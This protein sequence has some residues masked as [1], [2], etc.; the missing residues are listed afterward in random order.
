MPFPPL[1]LHDAPWPPIIYEAFQ[2]LKDRYDRAA[3]TLARSALDVP[4]ILFHKQVIE[5]EVVAL[6]NALEGQIQGEDVP[7]NLRAWFRQAINSF[8]NL[9]V[10]VYEAEASGTGQDSVRTIQANPVAIR[11]IGR[12][13]RPRKTI[14]QRLLHEAMAPHRAVSKSALA[15][16]LKIARGTLLKC[17]AEEDI[18]TG[19]SGIEDNELDILTREFRKRY[20]DSGIRYLRGF[21]RKYGLRIPRRRVVSSLKRTSGVRHALRGCH[22]KIMRRKYQVARPNAL[23]H[24]DGH[25]KL[26]RWGIVIHGIVDGYSRAV[27]GI[28]ASTSNKASTVLDVFMEAIHSY[29]IPS[30]VRGDRG[31]ENRDVSLFMILAR[32]PS[33]ASFMW[34]PSTR[35]TRIERLWGEVGSQFARAWRGFFLRLERL[36]Y[37]KHSNPHHLWLIQFIFLDAIN[38]DCKQFQENWNDHPISGVGHDKSPNDLRFLGQLEH[39]VYDGDLT[40]TIQ[41]V[42]HQVCLQNGHDSD[43]N[44]DIEMSDPLDE[45]DTDSGWTDMEDN[46]PVTDEWVR[47]CDE[48]HGKQHDGVKVPRISC[49]FTSLGEQQVFTQQLQQLRQDGI[50]PFGYGIHAEEWGNAGYPSFEIIKSGRGKK[51]LWVALPDEVWRARAEL[52]V[53]SLHLLTMFQ[54]IMN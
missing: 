46:S 18:T 6:F 19:F 15:R 24:I 26:I 10:Q 48:V 25:H 38:E 7:D 53:Q 21:L 29:G 41:Q 36:H 37:L 5:D 44:S 28:R 3:S 54:E 8:A 27:T 1:P 47:A 35:N 14:D 4:R 23:W 52:W 51:D 12:R 39:G 9:L 2:S 34:G 49:P 13:G 16:H 20:P 17:L 45:D 32:G 31:G 33:R 22:P 42:L 40:Q 30:R 43:S 50:V 11:R